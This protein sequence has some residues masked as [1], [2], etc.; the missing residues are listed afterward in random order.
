A[1]SE[2]IEALSFLDNEL[3]NSIDY[4]IEPVL[5]LEDVETGSLKVWLAQLLKQVPDEALNDLDWRPVLGQYLKKAKWITI[6]F[7]ESQT[8]V[9][10]AKQFQPLIEELHKTAED[11]QV[12]RLPFYAPPSTKGLLESISK[13]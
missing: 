3:I 11:T 12:K 10:D 9:T 4:R 2:L 13:I 7:L 6:N 8:E 1:A 5:L